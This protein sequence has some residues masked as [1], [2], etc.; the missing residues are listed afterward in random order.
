MRLPTIIPD[1]GRVITRSALK[2]IAK[3]KMRITTP[4]PSLLRLSLSGEGLALKLQPIRNKNQIAM[5][6]KIKEK[7]NGR[8]NF[9]CT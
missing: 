3:T 5:V 9:V 2:K 4:P 1:M 6:E 8:I 7:R